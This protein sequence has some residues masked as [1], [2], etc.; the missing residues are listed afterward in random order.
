M[1]VD[2]FDLN[3]R[4]RVFVIE[5]GAQAVAAIVDGSGSWGHGAEAADR[6]RDL[7]ADRWRRFEGWSSELLAHDISE[8]ALSTPDSL[9]DRDF[10]WSF[11]VTAV[12]FEGDAV[13]CV[14]AGLY[15]VDVLGAQGTMSVFRPEMAVDRLLA[16]GQLSLEGVDGSAVRDVCLGPFVGDDDRVQL[17]TARLSLGSSETLLVT[18]AAR[19]STFHGAAPQ[20]AR[21]LVGRRR[22]G[23]HPSPA[24]L[25][26]LAR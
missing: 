23:S 11:S 14:A 24:I 26:R 25:A 2:V 17:T 22:L 12:S 3:A 5:N 8:V 1:W 13:E 20:S 19:Y 18:N 10:G 4:S 9:R 7:L 15:R 6:A 21:E 16:D